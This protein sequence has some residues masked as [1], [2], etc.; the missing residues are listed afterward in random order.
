MKLTLRKYQTEDDYYRIRSFLRDVF[1]QNDRRMF[2]WPVF[3]WD[4]WSWHGILNLGDGSLEAGVCLWETEDRQIAAVLNREGAGQAFLQI[5]PTFKTEDLEEQMITQAE[6]H[7]RVPSGRGGQGLWIWSDSKDAQRHTILERRGYTPIT[8]ASE[9]Q[10]WR[11]LELPIPD[12]P[13]REGY[14]IRPLGDASELPSRSWA[15]WRSFHPDEP[16]DKYDGDW[17]WY[18]NIQTAPLY[19]RDLDLVAIT[20]DGDMAAFTTIWYD[21]VTRCG[22]FE[23]VGTRPE[24]QR[25]GLAR[26]LLCEG[27]RRLKRMGATQAVTIGGEPAANA[28]YQSVLGPDFDL[29]VPWGKKWPG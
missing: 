11:S 2:C 29:S 8:D 7:L 17:S 18:Q 22:Y 6:E 15:S 23:P 21:D 12:N 16:G 3:R 20:P 28:L 25:Q 1:L 14:S 19:R 13:V 27:M 24:H 9:H 4:Y 10:W 5:H 26:S